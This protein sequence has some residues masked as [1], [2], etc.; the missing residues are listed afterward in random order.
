MRAGNLY[1][2]RPV[3]ICFKISEKA[4]EIN[5]ELMARLRVL[6]HGQNGI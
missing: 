2:Q 4:P 1:M 6:T 5:R 3:R